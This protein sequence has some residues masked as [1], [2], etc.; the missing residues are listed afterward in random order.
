MSSARVRSLRAAFSWSGPVTASAGPG[1]RV[2]LTSSLQSEAGLSRGGSTSEWG[3]PGEAASLCAPIRDV[4]SV[5]RVLFDLWLLIKRSGSEHRRA[6]M[7]R[8][9]SYLGSSSYR[10]PY[11]ETNSSSY[12]TPS[13]PEYGSKYESLLARSSDG[14][15]RSGSGAGN[16]QC[17]ALQR[18]H[19]PFF[20][21][22]L[23]EI[24]L[25]NI[26]YIEF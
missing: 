18:I 8:Y 5:G 24:W 7:S 13:Y 17:R 15:S 6:K 23:F 19:E 12:G 14:S 10:S 16:M 1:G 26:L 20:S 2:S 4:K 11:S 21:R 22:S 3:Q 25:P 9:T